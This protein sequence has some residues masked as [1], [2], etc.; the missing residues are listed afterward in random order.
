MAEQMI[1]QE[2]VDDSTMDRDVA[3]PLDLST[4]EAQLRSE[5]RKFF[6]HSFSE[7]EAERTEPGNEGQEQPI[8]LS[9]S[10]SNE[11]NEL[12]ANDSVVIRSSQD[13]AESGDNM[14]PDESNDTTTGP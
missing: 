10:R 1:K 8:D 11:N 3:Q 14:N 12:P 5:L 7:D 6:P 13:A 9:N 2:I 4:T